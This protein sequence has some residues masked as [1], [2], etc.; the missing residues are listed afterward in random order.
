MDGHQPILENSV[1]CY[2]DRNDW[3]RNTVST[4][5]CNPCASNSYSN[6]TVDL[7]WDFY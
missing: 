7:G 5:A 3:V 2:G 6:S 1:V 4:I